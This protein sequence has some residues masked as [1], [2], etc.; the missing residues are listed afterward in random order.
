MTRRW[1]PPT[2]YTLRRNPA[3]IMKDFGLDL[4]FKL[5][6]PFSRKGKQAT[7][8]RSNVVYKLNCSCGGTWT[9]KSMGGSY[10]GQTKRNLTSRLKEHHPGNKTGTQTDVTKHLLEN[11][12]HVTN[13]YEPEILT[14]ANYPSD[15][16]LK[17]LYLSNNYPQSMLTNHP[18]HCL[19][20]IIDLIYACNFFAQY[21]NISY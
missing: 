2:R 1:A 12:S 10:I 13:F 4:T 19:C 20:S 14:T 18:H 6:S 9:S 21:F 8:R 11:P 17:K 7:L 3:S 16:L 5:G 15:L